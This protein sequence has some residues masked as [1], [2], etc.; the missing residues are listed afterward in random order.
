MLERLEDALA[1]LIEQGG[2]VEA[3]DA[4]GWTLLMHASATGRREVAEMLLAHGAASDART[5]DGWNP[6][7]LACAD[8]HAEVHKWRS[9]SSIYSVKYNY[10]SPK[11]FDAAGKLDI[12]WYAQRIQLIPYR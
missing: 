3:S 11:P 6:L 12:A 5:A 2:R 4:Q 1:R 10:G 8:G 9:N 7:M